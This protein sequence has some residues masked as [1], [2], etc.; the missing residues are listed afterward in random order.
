MEPSF[1]CQTPKHNSHCITISMSSDDEEPNVLFTFDDLNNIYNINQYTELQDIE[2]GIDDLETITMDK[3]DIMKLKDPILKVDTV[4]QKFDN[5]NFETINETL[6]DEKYT[7]HHKNLKKIE[8]NDY[9]LQKYE[10]KDLF[11]ELFE[12]LNI[13]NIDMNMNPKSKNY[14]NDLINS[15]LRE[16]KTTVNKL[17]YVHDIDDYDEVIKKKELCMH[18]IA[19]LLKYNK[20]IEFRRSLIIKRKSKKYNNDFIK[21]YEDINTYEAWDRK[22]LYNNIEDLNDNIAYDCDSDEEEDM[23]IL[24][25]GDVQDIKNYRLNKIYNEHGIKYGKLVVKDK[26]LVIEPFKTPYFRPSKS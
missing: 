17:C 21:K 20:F 7:N 10:S 24:N 4:V 22:F 1:A 23:I 14:K 3:E 5:Q 6:D 8:Y 9:L 13:L 25:L 19:K 2:D 18:E 12:D 11:E 16:I 26:E 15:V